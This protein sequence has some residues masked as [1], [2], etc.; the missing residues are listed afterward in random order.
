[1]SMLSEDIL[2]QLQ[3]PARYIAGEWNAVKKDL[4]KV[5]IKFALCFPDLYEVGM[6]NLGVR[7]LYGLL[8]EMEDVACER[9]FHPAADAEKLM[10]QSSIALSSLE[11]GLP[12][13]DFDIIGFSLGYELGYTNVLNM[14]DLAGIP[15]YSSQ[16][17][18]G[19]PL[20]IAGGSCVSN[21]E[22]LAAFIDLFLIGEGE[23]AIKEL[24][25]AYRQIRNSNPSAGKK[26]LLMA[27]SAIEGVYV[28]SFYDVKYGADGCIVSVSALQPQA[29][30]LVKKRIV[31]DLNKSFFPVK[32]M[33]PYIQII[34]DRVCL[35]VMRGCPN[36]CRF[37]QARSFYYPYRQRSAQVLL[38]LAKKAQN[39]SGYEEISLL[40]LS[41]TDYHKADEMLKDLIGNFMEKGVGVSLPSIKAK[42]VTGELLTL[43][44]K[45]KKSG[46]TLAP[47]AGTERLRQ[48]IGKDFNLDEFF[49]AVTQAYRLGYKHIK[50][51]FMIGLPGE[52]REDLDGI[53]ELSR[54]VSELKRK[55]EKGAA[56][57]NV[58]ASTFI[59]KPHTPFQWLAMDTQEKIEASQQYLSAKIRSLGP[60][61]KISFHDSRMSS[62]EGA[63]SRGDRRLSEVVFK[64][65]Q[66]GAKFDAWSDSFNGAFWAG[67]F[68]ESNLQ[69]DFYLSRQRG[70][71]EVFPW[72]FIDIGIGR[73]A[74]LSELEKALT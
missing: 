13:K 24:I 28:P 26:E 54:H 7:I 40:G 12:L 29:P 14:L 44:T 65:W 15:L 68:Q 1:M 45:I 71:D 18:Q 10:R 46:L 35:E 70:K 53:I 52:T 4:D 36:R 72:D 49:T 59:P 21:P 34:H 30:S 48:V 23:E 74:L 61:F 62:I 67:A 25:D 31:C 69:P 43:I 73:E 63:L 64:A 42:D 3:K 51:Y 22:P 11:S 20:V 66:K 38:D 41:V 27:L 50:L 60:K 55:V 37:C 58:S 2:L 47:E 8:N 6:S 17:E 56:N 9:A 39:S 16:R 32:W 33:V 19:F 57:V 5:S